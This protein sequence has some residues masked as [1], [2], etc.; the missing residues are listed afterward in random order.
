MSTFKCKSLEIRQIGDD[1][2]NLGVYKNPVL[3]TCWT[4]KH[5]FYSSAL[6]ISLIKTKKK[7]EA[8]FMSSLI[9]SSQ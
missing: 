2:V 8:A 3:R 4:E 7:Q 6:V 1:I 5:F 9:K